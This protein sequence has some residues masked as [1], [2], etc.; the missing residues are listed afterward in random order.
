[1]TTKSG[2]DY[3]R[4][5]FINAYHYKPSF[6][7]LQIKRIVWIIVIGSLNRLLVIEPKP[8]DGFKLSNDFAFFECCVLSVLQKLLVWVVISYLFGPINHAKIAK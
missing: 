5:S 6:E 7:K 8:T 1:M 4:I 3:L 2:C